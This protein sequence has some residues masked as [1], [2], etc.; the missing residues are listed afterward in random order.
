MARQ[1]TESS[2]YYW[3]V[4]ND[5][6]G[7]LMEGAW[8][9][10]L[11]PKVMSPHWARFEPW[12]GPWPDK[13]ASGKAERHEGM[14]SVSKDSEIGYV[15][16]FTSL[17]KARIAANVYKGKVFRVTARISNKLKLRPEHEDNKDVHT[18]HCCVRHGCKYS[19]SDCPVEAKKK[20]QSYHCESCESY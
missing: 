10:L 5:H 8:H 13:N 11:Y 12:V 9:Q 14:S 20:R 3:V 7:Y 18:E 4:K 6:G 19:H 17:R 16:E 2:R 15:H 1:M